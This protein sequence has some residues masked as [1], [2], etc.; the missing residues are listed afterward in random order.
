MAL[1]IIAFGKAGLAHGDIRNK[2]A[3]ARPMVMSTMAVQAA[4]TIQ[5]ADDLGPH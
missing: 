1:A 5:T 2:E 4:G 3:M